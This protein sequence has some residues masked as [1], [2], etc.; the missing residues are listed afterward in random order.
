MESNA[1]FQP[2]PYEEWI[3]LNPDVLTDEIICPECDGLCEA[4]CPCC[5]QMTECDRCSGSGTTVDAR[6]LYEK[7]RKKDMEK[8]AKYMARIRNVQQ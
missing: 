7:M 3:E 4:E 1:L 5:G 8:L 2:M 6:A